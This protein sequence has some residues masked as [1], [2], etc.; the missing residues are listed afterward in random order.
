MDYYIKDESKE[1]YIYFD[2]TQKCIDFIIY[3][4]NLGRN[5]KVKKNVSE[6]KS[7]CLKGIYI[8]NVEIL[9]NECKMNIPIVNSCCDICYEIKDLYPKCYT[10]MYPLCLDCFERISDIRCPYCRSI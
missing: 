6:N 8:K 9:I 7:C 3:I 10:C 4:N 2:T 5:I 1:L